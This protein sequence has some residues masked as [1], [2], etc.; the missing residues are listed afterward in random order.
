MGRESYELGKKGEDFA[1]C[2]LEQQGYQILE[3]NFR[4]S[5]GE[6]DLVAV[7]GVFLVFVEVKNYSFHS[8]GPPVASIRREKKASIIQAA[9][10][11][12]FLKKIK[13]RFCR[14]DVLTIYRDES[15]EQRVEL[16]KDAFQL[17]GDY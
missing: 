2:Y 7:E 4:S 8:F 6:I 1:V 13:D 5:H 17:R 9:K 14:F 10:T 16:Y 3:R 15:G 11:Y 12:L